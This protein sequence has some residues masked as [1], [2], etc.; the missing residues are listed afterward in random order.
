MISFREQIQ[1]QNGDRKEPCR[2]LSRPRPPPRAQSKWGR[3]RC[4]P[5]SHRPVVS[6]SGEPSDERLA[7]DVSPLLPEGSSGSVT[8]ARTGIRF[9]P[10][11]DL[12]EDRPSSGETE[13]RAFRGGR[14]SRAVPAFAE[15]LACPIDVRPARPACTG[16][17]QSSFSGGPFDFGRNLGHPVLEGRENSLPCI[18]RF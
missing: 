3:H 14:P 11:F 16:V 18:F 5:H 17:S 9:R 15:A 4:R 8:G 6:S 12:S 7:P 13:D 1:A 10:R 2:I